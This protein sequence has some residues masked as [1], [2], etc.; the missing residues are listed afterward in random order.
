MVN[1]INNIN[2]TNISFSKYSLGSY[3]R[4]TSNYSISSTIV[5]GLALF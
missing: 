3:T 2:F 4:V 1:S 5:F